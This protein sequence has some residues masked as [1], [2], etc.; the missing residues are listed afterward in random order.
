MATIVPPTEDST[1]DALPSLYDGQQL[2]QPEFHRLYEAIPGNQKFELIDGT[3]YTAAAYRRPHGRLG[4]LVAALLVAY[5]VAT[6]GVEGLANAT[7]ILDEKNEPEPDYQLRILS[8]YGGRAVVTADQYILGAPELV[9]EISH[10]TLN[11]DLKKKSVIY[12]E[13]GVK[14][15]WV[16]DVDAAQIHWF[17]WPEGEHAVDSDRV[18]RSVVFPGFWI[19]SQALFQEN[20]VQLQT[21]LN[22]G[23]QQPEHAS[24]VSHLKSLSQK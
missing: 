9:I 5:E 7:T 4:T 21:T 22:Q 20:I 3:V 17:V 23:L 1:A 2:L 14:E 19:D 10:S 11:L 13:Q 18:L 24:F 15:Y 8:E 16:V 12:K 6:P